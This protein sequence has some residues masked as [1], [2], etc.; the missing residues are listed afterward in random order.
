MKVIKKNIDWIG[1]EQKLFSG[2]RTI[3]G[4]IEGRK[5]APNRVG[6]IIKFWFHHQ[7]QSRELFTV[8]KGLLFELL[9]Y[10]DKGKC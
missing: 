3:T 10:I 6:T 8:V 5:G 1:Q 4:P 7:F 9:E 2:V